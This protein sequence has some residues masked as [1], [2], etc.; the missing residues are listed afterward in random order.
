VSSKE[1]TAGPRAVYDLAAERYVEFV[2]TEISGA[3]E[4]AIDQALLVAFTE[5]VKLGP[6]TRVADLGCGPGRVAAFMAA[7]GLQ[8]VGVDISGAMVAAA[9]ATHPHI[10]FEQGRIAELPIGNGQLAGAVCWYSIIY[11][12]PDHLGEVFVELG[13]V[14]RPGG[15]VLLAFQTGD[16]EPQHRDRAHGTNLSL[17]MYRHDVREVSRRLGDA[18]LEVFA[19]TVR[20][21]EF[22]HEAEPQAFVLGRRC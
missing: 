17:T 13:R 15:H 3:T 1:Y 10:A 20:D 7:Y 21:P 22:D 19:T 9:R 8:V 14:V 11:T 4:S 2:G 6:V 12:P 5:L 18:D 16:G